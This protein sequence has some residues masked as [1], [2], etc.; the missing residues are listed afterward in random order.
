MTKAALVETIKA[1]IRE[2]TGENVHV[3]AW[4]KGNK[5]VT[6]SVSVPVNI[7]EYSRGHSGDERYRHETRLDVNRLTWNRLQNRYYVSE[8]G[9]CTYTMSNLS[10]SE[11]EAIFNV[12][13]VEFL[14]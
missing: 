14:M 7:V 11:L 10:K 12:L 3:D 2:A 8:A 1:F 13:C 6:L 5:Y 4:S 9:G